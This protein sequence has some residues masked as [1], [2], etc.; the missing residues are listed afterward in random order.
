MAD[1]NFENVD[2]SVF[3][4]LQEQT[5]EANVKST[6]SE[7]IKVNPDKQ[8]H[9]N[10]LSNQSGIPAFAVESAP[11]EVES[12]L[13]FDNID[14]SQ[15]SKKSPKT[16]EYLTNF[17]NA[18]IAHD[19]IDALSAIEFNLQDVKNYWS[20]LKGGFE[21]G[22]LMVESSEIGLNRMR[23]VFDDTYTGDA[24]KRLDEIN[25]VL[26]QKGESERGFFTGA[27]IAAAEI[28]RSW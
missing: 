28:F 14:Y 27:P 10:K 4:K 20:D 8:A 5:S 18:S 21:K 9:I 6:M 3:D 12:R 7:A 1:L 19:D 16:A 22:Q 24:D 2:Y 23:S 13:N 15:M 17:E 26:M 25:A 11:E